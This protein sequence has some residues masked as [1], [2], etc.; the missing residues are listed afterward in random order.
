MEDQQ[1]LNNLLNEINAYR[2]QAELIQHQIELI[3]A[4]IAEVD[5]LSNT[6]DDIEGKD[7][8]EAFVPVGAGSF[9][10]GEL[11][12]TD[13]IIVSIGSG[14]AVKKD[15]DG[16]REIIAGQKEDL[17]DSLDK[18]LA[19]LQQVT[20]IVGNLQAQAEQLAAAAQGNMTQM[21]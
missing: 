21:R 6:L 2:Q 9:I 10:K 13:E 7:S 1:R 12:S 19:N 14:I 20:D 3:Q 8:V 18:M 4:S 17:K 11:K 5:A 15:A 16:A